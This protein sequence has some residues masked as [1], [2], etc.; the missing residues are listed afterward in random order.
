MATLGNPQN[1]IEVLQK[2]Q[3][4]FQKK[5]GQNFLID[6]HVLD[7]IVESAGITKDDC[8]LEI[9]PG[10]GTMTQYLAESARKVIAVEIDSNL[11]PILE[12]TLSAYDNVQVLNEDILKVDIEALAKEQNEGRPMKVV[13]NL[14]YY[15]TTP[16]IMG[17]LE[18][19]A[20]VDSIT[21]MVQKEVADRM[22]MTPGSKEYGALSLA[23]Q[24]YAKPEIVANVPPNCFMPRPN[25]GSAVI[26]L[27]L[28]EKPPVEVQDSKYM[29][30]LIRASFNQRRKT[31][32]NGLQNGGLGL[33]KDEILAALSEMGLSEMVRGETLS[34]EQFALLSDILQKNH[35]I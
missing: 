23:V 28:Y 22:Q 17:L 13:A 12:D 9:G 7:K 25:V 27:S 21:I 26:R 19:E 35:N 16:I 15:I 11:I 31:L 18:G 6:T 29:F 10:I 20:K 14:P 8:V 30:Q 33:T 2:Y 34:L 32:V 5:F 3:F 4:R 1:T 24:Y